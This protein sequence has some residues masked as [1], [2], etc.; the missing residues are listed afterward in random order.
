MTVVKLFLAIYNNCSIQF[1]KIAKINSSK[2]SLSQNCQFLQTI[3]K[4]AAIYRFYLGKS[5]IRFVMYLNSNIMKTKSL[6]VSSFSSILVISFNKSYYIKR[7]LIIRLLVLIC[8]NSYS[9]K[10]GIIGG[11]NITNLDTFKTGYN[12]GTYCEFKIGKKIS[13]VPNL[14]LNVLTYQNSESK[15]NNGSSVFINESNTTH[16]YN[17]GISGLYKVLDIGNFSSKIG[18][19]IEYIYFPAKRDL[20]SNEILYKGE[21]RFSANFLLNF[22]INRILKSHFGIDFNTNF[23]YIN[24][25]NNNTLKLKYP[26][27][28]PWNSYIL[29]QFQMGIFYELSEN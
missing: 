15:T 6:L 1:A 19:K 4:L 5:G 2:F 16:W 26:F 20:F 21:S 25:S 18:P 10:F 3:N 8:L 9:Q 11:Y 29:S 14:G 7:M 17:V 24:K 22:Q 27:A 23:G 12:V 28:R 13:I